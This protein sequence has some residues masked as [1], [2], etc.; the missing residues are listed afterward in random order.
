MATKSDR[1]R[2]AGKSV[3]P[4]EIAPDDSDPTS[5]DVPAPSTDAS[6]VAHSRFAVTLL[7]VAL[8]FGIVLETLH[9]FKSVTY[10]MDPVRKEFWSL[11]HFH[12]V[13]L[14]L[15]NLVYAS[16]AGRTGLGVRSRSASLSLMAG[17]VLLPLGFFLAGI[18]HYGSDP[19]LGIFLAP[20][21]AALILY[22]IGA[23][24]LALWQQ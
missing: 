4:T 9:G 21:G 22:A 15:V 17:S 10:L 24:A 7:L 23:N 3:R 6:V 14:S 12:G 8:A 20:V 16:W 2:K 11:A 1:G 19:G 18:A 13:G 5:A